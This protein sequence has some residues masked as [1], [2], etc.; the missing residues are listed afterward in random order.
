M[1]LFVYTDYRKFISQTIAEKPNKGRGEI[2]KMANAI[3]VHQTLIS[4]VLSGERDLSLEQGYALADYLGLT[5]LESEYFSLLIQFSKAG[6][7]RYKSA[8]KNKIELIYR[9]Y[10]VLRKMAEDKG[11]KIEEIAEDF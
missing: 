5:E 6:T 7:Q 4:L 11:K 1:S 3:G 9:S 2:S 10:P 8:V